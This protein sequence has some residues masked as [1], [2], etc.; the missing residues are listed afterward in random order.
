MYKIRYFLLT[1]LLIS[2]FNS[3]FFSKISITVLG[4]GAAFFSSK[5][6]YAQNVIYFL[7]KGSKNFE[8]GLFN[9]AIKNFKKVLELE[10]VG[11]NAEKAYFKI[12]FS[13][14][15]IGDYENALESSSALIKLN[16]NYPDAFYLRGGIYEK[17][18]QYQNA[19]DDLQMGV[20]RSSS[21]DPFKAKM[22]Y[23]LGNIK[24]QLR[25]YEGAKNDY[26]KSIDID[27]K[28]HT[29]YKD[30]AR[31][32]GLLRELESGIEDLN[33]AIYLKNDFASAYYIRA[34]FYRMLKKYKKACDD[35]EQANLYGDRR[36]LN[37]F[38]KMYCFDFVD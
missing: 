24:L 7:D 25:D 11:T 13:Y 30:R 37:E 26:S 2:S 15:E 9:N 14:M 10:N 18:K 28:W 8:N 31:A 29:V 21:D 33:R 6:L 27:P 38:N 16:P 17:L 23:S 4:T 1:T 5:T 35:Y 3:L 22:Y 12:A 19:L 36:G 32:K 20:Q 34:M